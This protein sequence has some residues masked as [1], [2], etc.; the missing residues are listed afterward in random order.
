LGEIVDVTHVIY[1]KIEVSFWKIKGIFIFSQGDIP[2][3]LKASSQA[4]FYGN[5]LFFCSVLIVGWGIVG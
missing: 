1:V 4:I 3:I 2:T 5:N